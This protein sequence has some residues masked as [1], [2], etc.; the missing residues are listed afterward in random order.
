MTEFEIPI[1]CKGC[2]KTCEFDDD[3]L[4]DDC[5]KLT[6]DELEELD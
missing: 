1:I 3:G 5:G 6:Y 2:G 4:C